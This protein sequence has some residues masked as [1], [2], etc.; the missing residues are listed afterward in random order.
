MLPALIGAGLAIYAGFLF[1]RAVLDLGQGA[2]EEIRG[3][4][5]KEIRVHSSG[6]SR[7]THYY[8]V[9]DG[10]DFEI[11][12]KAYAA[13]LDGL[14]YR[15]YYLPRTKTLLSIEALPSTQL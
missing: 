4:G 5:H 6:R 14:E 13:L 9:I 3:S 2:P 12:K 1:I 15:A 7:S 11:R 10:V 8:Y